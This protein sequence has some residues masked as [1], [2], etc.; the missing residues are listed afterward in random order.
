MKPHKWG[1]KIHLL[2]YSITKYLYNMIFDPRKDRKD[3][4]YFEDNKTIAEFIV[5]RLIKPLNDGKERNIF[6][7]EWYSS[8]SLLNKLSNLGYLNTTV[9]KNNVKD[10]S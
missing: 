5:L 1:F 4:I 6:F 7:D 9:L 2:C 3:F 10:M 8:I